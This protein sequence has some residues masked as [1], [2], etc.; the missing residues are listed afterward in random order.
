MA[1]WATPVLLLL[2]SAVDGYPDR[3]Y[4]SL[5]EAVVD[6]RVVQCS[7]STEPVDENG[8]NTLGTDFFQ[9]VVSGR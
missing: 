7:S 2:I 9:G 3:V 8:D 1:V 6:A 4:G 5:A